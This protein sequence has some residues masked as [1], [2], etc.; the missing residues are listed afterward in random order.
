M[1]SMSKEL[2]E[3]RVEYVDLCRLIGIQERFHTSPQD[4]GSAHIELRDDKYHY[5]V[6]ERGAEY[7]RRVAKD[8][9]EILYWLVSDMVF[10]AAMKYEGKNRVPGQSFR[11]L[12]FQKQIELMSALRPQWAVR[13]QEEIA[14]I[15]RDA[16]FDDAAEG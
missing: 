6:T 3:I 1:P 13:K 5:V 14:R 10:D 16:P 8:A 15:L 4:N 7:E 2:E 11:Q 9:D 12:L